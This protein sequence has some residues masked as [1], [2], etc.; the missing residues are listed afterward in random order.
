VVKPN[1]LMG[2]SVVTI[3]PVIFITLLFSEQIKQSVAAS[4]IKG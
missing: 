3:L 2:L 1:F 4:G